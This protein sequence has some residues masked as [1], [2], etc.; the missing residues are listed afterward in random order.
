[1]RVG[2]VC[3]ARSGDKGDIL[4]LTLVARDDEAYRLIE[5]SLTERAVASSLDRVARVCRG[6]GSGDA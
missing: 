5:R 1:M 4:D 6:S 3:A 2:D